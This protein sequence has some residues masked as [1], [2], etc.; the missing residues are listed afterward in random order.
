[1]GEGRL[2]GELD[3][4]GLDQ[5]VEMVGLSIGDLV[6]RQGVVGVED[7]VFE[8]DALA[9][10]LVGHETGVEA[11]DDALA[12]ARPVEGMDLPNGQR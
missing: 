12:V 8:E 6:V 4:H 11:D 9:R 2:E 3:A 7:V 5:N 1:M 10:L